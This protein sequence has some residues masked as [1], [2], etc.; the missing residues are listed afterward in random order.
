MLKRTQQCGEL[1]NLSMEPSDQ[2]VDTLRSYVLAMVKDN[3]DGIGSS[4]L[5][6]LMDIVDEVKCLAWDGNIKTFG[7]SVEIQSRPTCEKLHVL[8]DTAL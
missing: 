2:Q 7:Q 3:D 5:Q 4:Q 8:Q 6:E 1:V